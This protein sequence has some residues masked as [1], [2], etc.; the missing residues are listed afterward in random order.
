MGAINSRI[1]IKCPVCES[2]GAA[3]H[4]DIRAS[5]VYSCLQ[6]LHTWQ[7]DPAEEPSQADPAAVDDEL[8]MPASPS[9][10]PAAG[11]TKKIM[12]A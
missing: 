9:A 3:L 12:D 7:I 2:Q 5:L 1:I 4:H 10:G 11:S 6:C 8:A